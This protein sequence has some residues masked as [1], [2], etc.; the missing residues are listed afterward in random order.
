[1]VKLHSIRS[2]E[3]RAKDR[4]I[5]HLLPSIRS[6]IGSRYISR[7]KRDGISQFLNADGLFSNILFPPCSVEL[8][9]RDW[10]LIHLL[11]KG[12]IRTQAILARQLGVSTRTVKRNFSRLINSWQ[13]S[14]YPY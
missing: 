13:Y 14:P 1:M 2:S 9:L 10:E 6:Y 4:P 11:V 12:D 8:H 5:F 7:G 3:F